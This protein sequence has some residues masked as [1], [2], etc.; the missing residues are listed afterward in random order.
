M[1]SIERINAALNHQE[2]D[3]IPID[4]GGH[5]ITGIHR[6]AYEKL[7][8]HLEYDEIITVERYRQRTA[9][10][11][12]KVH[13]RFSTDCRPLVPPFPDL[14]WEQSE[15]EEW[16][17]DEW[18]VEW[19]RSKDDGLYFEHHKAYFQDM[20]TLEELKVKTWPDYNKEARFAG[21]KEKIKPILAQEKVPIL[22]LPLGLEIFDAG[23]NICG[24]TNFY[25]LLALDPSAALYLMDRQLE[26]QL[27][28]WK[29]AI[30]RM[31][32]LNLIRIGDDLGG[33]D[34][35]LISPEMYR[36]LVLPRHRKLFQGIKEASQGKVKIIMHCDGAILP[37]LPDMIDAGIDCL[38]PIQYSIEGIDPVQLKKEFGRDITFWGG[39]IDTQEILR[40]GSVQ[41]VED[42]VKK[43]IDIL[44]P[45]GGFVF[46]QIHILQRDI[47][48][49]N[50]AAMF[51]AAF[52]YGN[53]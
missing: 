1:N 30:T 29:G 6:D 9:E 4:F 5:L 13:K 15:T 11:S 50:I 51:D 39:G 16:Y 33:Q 18:G 12:E 21:L 22:D 23:F 38:N 46:S 49:E 20:P 10:I 52:T 34:A 48:S 7:I 8:T 26:T 32:E 25:M 42:E 53:Y 28:W 37:I 31:P 19:N 2:A 36:D 27:D 47:P 45:G 44:A 43:Q 3:R 41:M 35:M 24:A 40:N 14:Y 17:T